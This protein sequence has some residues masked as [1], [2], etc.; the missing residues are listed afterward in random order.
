MG[1][2]NQGCMTKWENMH[3]SLRFNKYK[4]CSDLKV[5]AKS[6]DFTTIVNHGTPSTYLYTFLRYVK[7]KKHNP[8]NN[9]SQYFMS[10]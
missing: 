1:M 8:K 2:P 6:H 7:K 9:I 3:N 10:K 4:M 5:C